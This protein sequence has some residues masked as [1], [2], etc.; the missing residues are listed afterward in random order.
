MEKATAPSSET[1]HGHQSSDTTLH[2]GRPT[3]PPTK[4]EA[5]L[6]T[7]YRAGDQGINQPEAY[8]SYG[9][10]CLHTSVSWAANAKDLTIQRVPEPHRTPV[11]TIT[12]FTRYTLADPES[13]AKALRIINGYRAARGT[14]PCQP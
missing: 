5:F 6:L 10:S 7:L 12:H 13:R 4:Y 9:E 1:R 14:A 2:Q 3:K 8:Q 11:G